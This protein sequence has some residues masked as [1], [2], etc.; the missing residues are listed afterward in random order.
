MDIANKI[1][2]DM[3]VMTNVISEIPLLVFNCIP[4]CLSIKDIITFIY[5]NLNNLYDIL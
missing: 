1:I 5:K 3:I 4:P 2:I